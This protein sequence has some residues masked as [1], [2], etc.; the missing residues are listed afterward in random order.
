VLLKTL[1]HQLK[2]DQVKWSHRAQLLQQLR[3]CATSDPTLLPEVLGE[4]VV[5]IT[6]QKNPNVVRAAAECVAFVSD[7]VTGHAGCG[8][9]W[10]SLLVETVHLLRHANKSVVEGAKESL[11]AMH[12]RSL[13]L[14]ALSPLLEDIIAG[15]RARAEGVAFNTVRVTQW[16][17]DLADKELAVTG[18]VSDAQEDGPARAFPR[19]DVP[20]S[21]L[22]CRPLLQSKEEATRDS[23]SALMARLLSMDALLHTQDSGLGK[24]LLEEPLPMEAEAVGELVRRLISTAS[25]QAIESLYL[26]AAS[27]V[28]SAVVTPTV[29]PAV[30]ATAQR[31]L[32]R[33]LVETLRLLCTHE[34]VSMPLVEGMS[35]GKLEKQT[36]RLSQTMPLRGLSK[37]GSIRDA[38]KEDPMASTIGTEIFMTPNSRKNS[39]QGGRL[40]R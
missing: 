32:S 33:L 18:V 21:L 17:S 9:T 2:D 20:S 30:D 15:P 27:A 31:R 34:G 35:T 13:S 38:M 4:L 1:L 11:G 3:S 24:P 37:K 36:S 28:S 5:N 26:P 29:T 22:R 39:M 16:L 23:A 14:S 19:V 10:R 7:A 12:G 40:A 8:A 6:K 25:K